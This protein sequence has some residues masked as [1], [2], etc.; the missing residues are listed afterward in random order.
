M[1]DLVRRGDVVSGKG[2][3]ADE[4]EVDLRKLV[5]LL[6]DGEGGQDLVA[7]QIRKWRKMRRKRGV[8]MNKNKQEQR[9]EK[10]ES[11]VSSVTSTS[12]SFLTMLQSSLVMLLFS[13][14]A[15]QKLFNS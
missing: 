5:D 12:T 1:T 15:R 6:V 8:K 7:L 10:A 13:A 9:G 11:V 3:S 2:G 14:S 4:L